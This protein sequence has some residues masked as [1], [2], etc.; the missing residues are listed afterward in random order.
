MPGIDK[1]WEWFEINK[2]NVKDT[3][4]QV[5][6]LLNDTVVKQLAES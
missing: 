4:F 5:R 3:L 6:D 2:I 1:V